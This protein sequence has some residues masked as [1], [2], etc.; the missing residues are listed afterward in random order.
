M[1]AGGPPPTGNGQPD[2]ARSTLLQL[3]P[4]IIL[5]LISFMGSLPSLF[6]TSPPP[7][8][9]YLFSPQTPYT[10]PRITANLHIPYYVSPAEF[11]AHPI[12]SSVPDQ[13]KDQPNAGAHSRELY[14]FER[15]IEKFW[16]NQM[17][18]ACELEIDARNR[19]ADA[20]RGW[21][22]IG[23]D[24]EAVRKIERENLESC[25]TLKSKNLISRY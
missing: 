8:P 23:A 13:Y 11:A 1:R 17:M 14:T 7:N 4:L 20:K 10:S 21:L 24:W 2:S 3:A 15:S 6:S 12:W 25:E 5:F 16:T 22:G 18:R 9:S 19:R